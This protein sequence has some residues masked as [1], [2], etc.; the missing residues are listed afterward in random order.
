MRVFFILA[1]V[2]MSQV[3]F[4]QAQDIPPIEYFSNSPLMVGDQPILTISCPENLE[5]VNVTMRSRGERIERH[6]GRIG[7]GQP[8]EVEFDSPI[9]VREWRVTVEGEWNHASFELGFN[10]EFDVSEGLEISIPLDEVDLEGHTLNLVLNRSASHVLYSVISDEGR[11]MGSGRVDFDGAP[12][13]TPLRIEWR[14]GAGNI[15]KISLRVH[16]MDGFWAEIEIIP[17]SV[18]IPHE[19]V[20]FA[21]GSAEIDASEQPKI[22]SAYQQLVDAVDRYGEFVDINL[23]IGGYT[24]TVGSRSDNQELSNRRARSI[25]S[26]FRELGFSFPIYYQGFGEDGLA[27]TTPDG[28]DE[29]RNR[30]ALYILAAQ[31]PLRSGQLPRANWHRID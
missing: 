28:T 30:R 29:V 11:D 4:A 13:N 25:A 1:G 8:A 7:R 16:D 12:A 9:G 31:Q 21:T 23:Y 22:D 20:H 17:W 5:E 3:S 14:Q 18:E 26:A 27:V 15:L 6:F 19:E 24:D 10:F 2:L